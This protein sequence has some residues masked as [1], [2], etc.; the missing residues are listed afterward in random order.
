MISLSFH[1]YGQGTKVYLNIYDLAPANEYLYNVGLGLHHSGVE[2]LGTEYSFASGAGIFNA[3]P[4]EAPG[5]QFRESIYMG[6]FEGNSSEINT[7]ISDLRSDF[8][9]DSYN[10]ILR[11]CNHFANALCWA[12]LNKAI[13][14]YV[15][16]LADLGGCCKCL[17]PKNLLENAPVGD[18][19]GGGQSSNASSGFQVYGNPGSR[20]N[21]Q[22]T[23]HIAF[24]GTGSTL[25]NANVSTSSASGG[26]SSRLMG[27]FQSSPRTAAGSNENDLTDRRERARKAALAR[28]EKN[29]ESELTNSSPTSTVSGDSNREGLKRH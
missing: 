21:V 20:N 1:I 28:L 17:I 16:R 19:R 22:E 10:L 29:K 14:G 27:A 9:G 15:N 26:M 6:M 4:K 24:S 12:L 18:D 13:P 11:N 7:V 25:G 3:P 2:I 8:T 5:A 23:S